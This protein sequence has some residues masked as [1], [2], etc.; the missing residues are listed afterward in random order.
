MTAPH[1]CYHL[2]GA[3]RHTSCLPPACLTVKVAFKKSRRD[4][5]LVAGVTRSGLIL[6]S[7]VL[8]LGAAVLSVVLKALFTESSK[9]S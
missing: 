1:L 3:L 7:L 6:S 8:S 9:T 4:Y 2:G 5:R